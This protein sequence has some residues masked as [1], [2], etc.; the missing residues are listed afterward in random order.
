MELVSELNVMIGRRK[1]VVEVNKGEGCR[2]RE[3]KHRERKIRYEEWGWKG[4]GEFLF[5]Y[6]Y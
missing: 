4:M 5:I 2:E 6:F 1:V 3:N